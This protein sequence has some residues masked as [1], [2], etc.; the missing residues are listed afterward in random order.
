MHKPDIANRIHQCSDR[1]TQAC[2]VARPSEHSNPIIAG[3]ARYAAFAAVGASRQIEA[4][5]QK[6]VAVGLENWIDMPTFDSALFR[7]V[8]EEVTVMLENCGVLPKT[9]PIAAV[10][11]QMDRAFSLEHLLARDE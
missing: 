6:V 10:F 11:A 4:P 8:D 1:F 5:S 7:I 3:I 2:R 9:D